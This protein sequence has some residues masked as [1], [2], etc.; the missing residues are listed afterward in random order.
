MRKT[1]KIAILI[2]FLPILLSL[3]TM[4][5]DSTYFAKYT[6]P[7][8]IHFLSYTENWDEQKLQELYQELI[9]NT[10]G[11]E[12]NLL[13]EVRVRGDAK[14]SDSNTR[15]QYHSLTNTI[16]L[17]HGDMYLEPTDFRE[18]LSHEYGH[19][20]SYHYF[21][22]QHFPTS[23]WANLRGLGDMPVRWDA[24]WNYS[25]TSHK[26]YPQEIMA[27]DYVLLY[28]A[29]KSVEIKDVYSNEA[30]YRKTV[31]DNDYISNVLEN[32]SLHHLFEDVT[33]FAI[34]SNRYLETP[35]FENFH[36]GIAS[37]KIMKKANI[38][39]RL[40][41][42]YI[43]EDQEKYEELLFITEDDILDEISFLLNKI[44]HS[45][46]IIE[47]SL[48]VLDLSTSLGL[49]TKKITIQL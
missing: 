5:Y 14:P 42:N 40:N 38:A 27:D 31:H 28:G 36:E 33:G 44:D 34:D 30:F 17:F 47:L 8:N 4:T 46:R 43:K 23:N 13:Q 7:E 39:Y 1:L 21:P 49:Q 16:T 25:T 35:T 18:T 3:D 20:F 9:L 2:V 10:H 11:E 37:F 48:D 41:V 19:H 26:W 22:E 12:I 15:G 6:S 32:T 29:T 45:T 24:F